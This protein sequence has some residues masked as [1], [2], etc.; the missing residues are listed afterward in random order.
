[1]QILRD[2]AGFFANIRRI[3]EALERLAWPQDVRHRPKDLY[4]PRTYQSDK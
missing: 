3:R 1:M 4:Q 2:V